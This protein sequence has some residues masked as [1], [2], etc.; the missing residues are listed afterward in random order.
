[1]V[2]WK[3]SALEKNATYAVEKRIKFGFCGGDARERF[4]L[5]MIIDNDSFLNGLG[6]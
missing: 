3:R 6:L 5:L 2:W 1:M 4:A